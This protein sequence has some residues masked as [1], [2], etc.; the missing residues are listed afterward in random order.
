MER[1][2]GQMKGRGIVLAQIS[3]GSLAA[4]AKAKGKPLENESPF[5][6]IPDSRI[7]VHGIVRDPIKDAVGDM[8]M[9][10]FLEEFGGLMEVPIEYVQFIISP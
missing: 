5:P 2:Y 3:I 1:R 9:V 4:Y 10:D 6:G 8:V 7:M